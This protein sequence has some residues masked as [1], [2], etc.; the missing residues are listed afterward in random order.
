MATARTQR[1][2]WLLAVSL[3]LVAYVWLV[4][5][6]GFSQHPRVRQRVE[7]LQRHGIEPAAMFYTDLP[8]MPV[9]ESRVR[10]KQ[11]QPIV[12]S[13]APSASRFNDPPL[14]YS[15]GAR[16]TSQ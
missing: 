2:R 1:G 12:E 14:R 16:S 6:P 7:H 15:V 10:S 8:N 11:M 13:T 4:L 5:L 9:W 3:L